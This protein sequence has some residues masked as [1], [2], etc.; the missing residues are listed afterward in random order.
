MPFNYFHII[1]KADF[2]SVDEDEVNKQVCEHFNFTY[3]EEDYGQFYFTEKEAEEF[4]QESI[5]WVE[6]IDCIIYYS[7]SLIGSCIRNK[8]E[9]EAALAWTRQYVEMPESTVDF[10][11]DLLNFLEEKGYYI[12]VYGHSVKKEYDFY[13]NIYKGECLF[14][15]G[16][17]VFHCHR[18]KLL[19]F[20]PNI[21]NLNNENLSGESRNYRYCIDA[22]IIPEGITSIE[23]DSFRYGMIKDYL[24]FPSTLRSIGP[25]AFAETCLPEIIIPESVRFI[26]SS[27][28]K[29]S[30]IRSVKIS[31]NH[32]LDSECLCL[33]N[34]AYIETLYWPYE[35]RQLW[36]KR[37]HSYSS[38][39]KVHTV[40]F[41]KNNSVI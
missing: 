4:Q 27:T 5:S 18:G 30:V 22:L 40:V 31:H 16:S 6:L 35:C 14:E 15:N 39:P 12:H 34:G 17:G 36:E 20:F 23:E 9:I 21:R 1:N 8:Y 33:F 19:Y 24:S 7:L 38:R 13:Q 11:S 32:T 29:N 26:D 2:T 10:L 41:Y 37:C 28:F 3:S 25:F